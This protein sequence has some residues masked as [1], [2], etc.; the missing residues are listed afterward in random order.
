MAHYVVT[1]DGPPQRMPDRDAMERWLVVTGDDGE[2]RPVRVVL[3]GRRA[4]APTDDA[5][6][7]RRRVANRPA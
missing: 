3:S 5:A 2:S 4:G 7:G 6:L 1:I